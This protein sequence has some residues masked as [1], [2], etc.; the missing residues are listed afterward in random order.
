M[1][2]GKKQKKEEVTECLLM[3]N[4][5]M[6][7]FGTQKI[8]RQKVNGEWLR[9]ALFVPLREIEP[10]KNEYKFDR[11]YIEFYNKPGKDYRLPLGIKLLV[12]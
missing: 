12:N 6:I 7:E 10:K 9:F 4:I 11:L 1:Y 8:L 5:V 2:N 3:D